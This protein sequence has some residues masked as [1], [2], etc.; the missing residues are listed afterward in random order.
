[1]KKCIL[2]LLGLF[3]TLP[4]FSKEILISKSCDS[5]G[6]CV[7]VYRLTG[8]D[9]VP[10]QKPT[11]EQQFREKLEKEMKWQ[12]VKHAEY[13]N[14]TDE[15]LREEM[16]KEI[17][18]YRVKHPEYAMDNQS[19]EDLEKEIKWQRVKHAEYADLSD[20]QVVARMLAEMVR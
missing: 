17:K 12:K 3:L 5:K 20:E 2:V 10:Y 18:R 6:D 4:C 1:M 16:E 9:V 15:Q 13:A 7:S 8:K 14:L 11:R 19:R